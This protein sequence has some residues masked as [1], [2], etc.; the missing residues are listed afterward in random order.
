MKLA[1]KAAALPVRFYRRWLSP[2]KPPMCRFSPTCSAYAVEALEVHGV[3]KGLALATW[4]LL[5]CQPFCKGGYDPVPPPRD[6]TRVDACSEPRQ[7]DTVAHS[8]S[9][10]STPTPPPHSD[11]A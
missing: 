8:A 3:V 6:R 10:P 2:L 11:D 5:R 7:V 9:P 1:G 4:R